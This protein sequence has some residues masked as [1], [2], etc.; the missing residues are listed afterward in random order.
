MNRKKDKSKGEQAEDVLAVIR[1]PK[2][3][4]WGGGLAAT[5]YFVG[6]LFFL[7]G[8]DRLFTDPDYASRISISCFVLFLGIATL[9][10]VSF[11]LNWKIE[12]KEDRFVFTNTFKKRREY[13]FEEIEERQLRACYRY[14]HNGKHIVGI[15]MLLDDFYMLSDAIA[16]YRAKKKKEGEIQ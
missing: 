7:L 1:Q 10:L 13:K 6:I 3:Y 12:V 16:A 15:S 11:Q 5:V 2:W 4:L 8:P 9:F 14:Y